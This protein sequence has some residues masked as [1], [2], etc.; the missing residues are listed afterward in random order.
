M[1]WAGQ[2]SASQTIKIEAV[3]LVMSAIVGEPAHQR[4]ASIPIPTSAS[5]CEAQPKQS[6]Q[7]GVKSWNQ[8]TGWKQAL[9]NLR[10]VSLW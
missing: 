9:N 4:I 2:T 8:A 10:L 3:G 6:P 1:S 7:T 5:Q